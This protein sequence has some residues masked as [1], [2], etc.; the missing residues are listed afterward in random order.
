MQT[1]ICQEKR[2]GDNPRITI[3]NTEID[4]L[5]VNETIAL[6]EKYVQT[7]TPLAVVLMLFQEIYQ[8]R[9]FGYNGL[10]LNGFSE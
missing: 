3:L 5:N 2:L 9:R 10:I 4:V 8:E 7:K 1:T 6:V